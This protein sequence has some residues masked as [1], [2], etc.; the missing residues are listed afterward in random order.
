[1]WVSRCR[2]VM[3]GAL[4]S[5]RNGRNSGIQRASLSSTPR[6]PSS[7]SRNAAA[8]TTVLVSEASRNRVASVIGR[9]ASRSAEP[10]ARA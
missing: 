6:R 3:S 4:P 9:P 2:T 1:M 7:T 5:A 8:E 10:A